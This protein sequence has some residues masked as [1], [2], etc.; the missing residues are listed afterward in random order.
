MFFAAVA[1]NIACHFVTRSRFVVTRLLEDIPCFAFDRDFRA[2]G[3]TV[4]A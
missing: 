1:A 2:S 3:V 4:I